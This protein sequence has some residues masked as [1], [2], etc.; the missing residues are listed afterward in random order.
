MA[1]K[2]LRE[3][4]KIVYPRFSLEHPLYPKYLKTLPD[5][6]ACC[7]CGIHIGGQEAQLQ[8]QHR[9]HPW[10]ALTTY[11]PKE[12]PVRYERF[13]N[14]LFPIIHEQDLVKKP[15]VSCGSLQFCSN[16]GIKMAGYYEFKE[17]SSFVYFLRHSRLCQGC[18]RYSVNTHKC[19]KCLSVR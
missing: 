9:F 16:E 4:V 11:K 13:K 14:W 8:L 17:G 15:I 18:Q 6:T 10:F 19:S 2:K 5:N 12:V 7:F 1:L 3:R